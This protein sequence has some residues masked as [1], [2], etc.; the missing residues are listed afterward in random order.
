[1]MPSEISAWFDQLR[2]D[3]PALDSVTVGF[4]CCNDLNM[5]DASAV[6]AV[7]AGA[8]EIKAVTCGGSAV[9]LANIVRI[10]SVKGGSIGV[11]T[12]VG[13][14]QLRRIT[15][16]VEMICSATGRKNAAGPG[17]RGTGQRFPAE[18]ARYG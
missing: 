1:M 18:R 6:A 9:S 17:G 5:A 4:S 16:Q 15:G 14:E 7:R 11:C 3:L 2:S 10:L 12:K 8:R 13:V